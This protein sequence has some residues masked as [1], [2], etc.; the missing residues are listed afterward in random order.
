[1]P[2]SLFNMVLG[3]LVAG[4]LLAGQIIQSPPAMA[5]EQLHR[6]AIHVD[7]NDPKRINIV[8]NN[9][10]NAKKYY[11]SI[12]EAVQIEIVAHGPGLHMLRADTSTVKE[13]ISAMSLE[14]ENLTFSACGNTMAGMTKK[15]G[16]EIELISE[17]RVVPSGVIRLVELQEEGFAYVRP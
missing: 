3:L 15:E 16:K 8:L 5:G 10:Q 7:E 6:I 9:A 1:M 12:G 14:N 11:D 13:R 2:K 17:A 4:S